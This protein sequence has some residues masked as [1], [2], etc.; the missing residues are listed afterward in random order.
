MPYVVAGIALCLGLQLIF[1][2]QLSPYRPRLLILPF[3]FAY[4]QKAIVDLL[5]Y[6]PPWFVTMTLWLLVYVALGLLLWLLIDRHDLS[7]A[8]RWRR[9]AAGW[10]AV[11]ACAALLAR[12][13]LA[14]GTINIE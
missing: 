8:R 10:I 2:L 13:L 4:S 5:V 3:I 1:W 6:E 7:T 11:E 14:R 12:Y 9:A